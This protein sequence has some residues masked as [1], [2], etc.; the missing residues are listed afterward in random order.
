[1]EEEIGEASSRNSFTSARDDLA[2]Q[3]LPITIKEEV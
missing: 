1:M 3:R 2:S